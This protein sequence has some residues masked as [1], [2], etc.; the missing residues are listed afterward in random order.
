V[1]AAVHDLLE[2]ES[3]WVRDPEFYQSFGE[4]VESLRREL[5]GLLRSLKGRTASGSR[6]ME[7]LPREAHC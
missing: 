7:H 5:V 2:E 4:R 1:K 6:C 3:S